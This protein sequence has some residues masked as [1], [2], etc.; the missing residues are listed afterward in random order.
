MKLVKLTNMDNEIIKIIEHSKISVLTG[1]FYTHFKADGL[2]DFILKISQY[3]DL[4]IEAKKTYKD[5]DYL[6][7]TIKEIAGYYN[8]LSLKKL[9]EQIFLN[10]SFTETIDNS[11]QIP[12]QENVVSHNFVKIK[13]YEKTNSKAIYFQK[14]SFKGLPEELYGKYMLIILKEDLVPYITFVDTQIKGKS[15]AFQPAPSVTAFINKDITKDIKEGDYLLNTKD[16]FKNDQGQVFYR[17]DLVN[18]R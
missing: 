3:R 7:K 2:D 16:V 1:V 13:F 6:K 12:K 4:P 8:G 17:L 10:N 5:L 11:L 9:S 14:N 18:E 15:Y